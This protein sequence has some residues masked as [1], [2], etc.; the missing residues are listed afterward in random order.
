[1]SIFTSARGWDLQEFLKP[2]P[3]S[4]KRAPRKKAIVLNGENEKIK[5]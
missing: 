2:I 4:N 5:S 1:M 3:I